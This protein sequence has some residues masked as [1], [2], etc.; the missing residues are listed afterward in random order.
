MLSSSDDNS[1]YPI[2][3]PVPVAEFGAYV[4][5]QHAH[6]NKKFVGRFEVSE[7]AC[8]NL[9]NS[10]LAHYIQKLDTGEQ[11]HTIIVSGSEENR[12]AN[13][14]KNITI[15]KSIHTTNFACGPVLR[16]L[17]MLFCR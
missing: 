10:S 17:I 7:N 2:N 13:R 9:C 12:I 14:F 8:A 3:Q 11:G 6:G 4:T 16:L 15:C 5:E 1:L